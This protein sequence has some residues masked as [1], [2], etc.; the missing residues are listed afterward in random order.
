MGE[1]ALLTTLT[2]SSWEEPQMTG[3]GAGGGPLELL[4]CV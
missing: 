3:G 4:F 1:G 2:P